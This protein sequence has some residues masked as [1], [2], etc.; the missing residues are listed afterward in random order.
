ML[1]ANRRTLRQLIDNRTEDPEALRLALGQSGPVIHPAE[2][3]GKAHIFS[4]SPNTGTGWQEVTYPMSH[5]ILE[6]GDEA[7]AGDA[8]CAGGGTR[9]LDPDDE[10]AQEL[11]P[12]EELQP[13]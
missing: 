9:S 13:A 11:V 2:E 6:P 1:T 4:T 7:E 10:P 3:D 12:M 5:A 8:S